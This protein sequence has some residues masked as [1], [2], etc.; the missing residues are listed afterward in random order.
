[1][2]EVWASS[3]GPTSGK[4]EREKIKVGMQEVLKMQK[5]YRELSGLIS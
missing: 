4:L 5:M 1:M 2:L 3:K